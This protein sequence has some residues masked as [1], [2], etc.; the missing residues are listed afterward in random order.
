[1]DFFSYPVTLAIILITCLTSYRA[2]TDL[3]LKGRLVFSPYRAKNQGE[4]YRI[5]SHSLIHSNM[6]HLVFNMIV[7]FS[8]GIQL[9]DFLTNAFGDVDGRLRYLILYVGAAVFATLPGFKKYS[10][11]PVYTSLGAFGAAV[12]VLMA[13]VLIYPLGDVY[14]MFA[15]RVPAWTFLILFFVFESMMNKK[16]KTGIAHDAHIA[17][18]LFGLAY[19]TFIDYQILINFFM[20]VGGFFGL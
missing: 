20:Q 7:V 12:A 6:I 8:F 16:G 13:E 11:N 10:E 17:G 18:A 2:F 9:E 14:L 5:I 15:I 3:E 19:I 4:W 1:M